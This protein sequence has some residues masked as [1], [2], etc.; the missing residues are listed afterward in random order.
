MDVQVKDRLARARAYVQDR[1]ISV[2][3]FTLARNLCG[4]EMTA[5]DDFGVSGLCFFQSGEMALRND[6][7]VRGSLRVDIFE[8]VDMI[9]FVHFPG[10]NLA[11]NDAA[12]EAVWVGHDS[13]PCGKR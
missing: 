11:S 4:R 12:E 8:G 9:V 6:E 7:H 13:I 1:S 2:L 10:S 3:D 5:A